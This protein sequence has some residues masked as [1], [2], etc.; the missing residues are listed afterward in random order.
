M[1]H[2]PPP[3]WAVFNHSSPNHAGWRGA[4]GGGARARVP[5]PSTGLR[6]CA[7]SY[8]D[9]IVLIGV[10]TEVGDV[11]PLQLAGQVD[12]AL[13]EPFHLVS[14]LPPTTD[15]PG[16]QLVVPGP[17]SAHRRHGSGHG[18]RVQPNSRGSLDDPG[19]DKASRARG[20]EV[21]PTR[22]EVE[23]LEPIVVRIVIGY[24]PAGT[25]EVHIH[26]RRTVPCRISWSNISP[27]VVL[28]TP[29]GP[30]RNSTGTCETAHMAGE[31]SAGR[32]RSGRTPRKRNSLRPALLA[33]RATQ[34]IP[35]R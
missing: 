4:S 24:W 19:G 13:G 26:Q 1:A 34:T 7:L 18:T 22:T 25:E 21:V 9:H 23:C 28:P 32:N 12:G 17:Q 29:G 16:P 5:W 14:T 10:D 33:F 30:E 3:V 15:D 20:V 31:P 11:V 35:H 27:T 2:D 6:E 8:L